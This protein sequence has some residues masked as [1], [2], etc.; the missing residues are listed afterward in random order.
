MRSFIQNQKNVA[1]LFCGSMSLKDSLI[2]DLNGK[3]GAFGG[4]M[5]TI[6]IHPFS[7]Q[8]TREYI[9]S[10]PRNILLMMGDLKDFTNALEEYLITSTYLQKSFQKT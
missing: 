1:Y 9:E 8:T 7:K 3:E 6:E 10:I 4:R 5:L 2:N